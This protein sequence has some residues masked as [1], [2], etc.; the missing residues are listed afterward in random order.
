[1]HRN[2]S[3]TSQNRKKQH[4]CL[5]IYLT[6]HMSCRG[7]LYAHKYKV[8]THAAAWMNLKN[9]LNENIPKTQ[10]ILGFNLYMSRIGNPTEIE[11]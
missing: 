6:H 1:M 7:I 4:Q 11:S 9:I 3:H 8:L 5:S 2:I 10:N